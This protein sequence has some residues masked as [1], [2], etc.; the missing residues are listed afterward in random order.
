MTQR[1]EPSDLAQIGLS[2]EGERDLAAVMGTGWF[3]AAQDA[4]R[5]AIA[6]ALAADVIASQDQ[7]KG[8]ETKYNFIGGIDDDGKI[9][10]LIST[11][12]PDDAKMPARTAERLAHAG[13]RI[14][15]EKLTKEDALLSVSIGYHEEAVG[16]EAPK[17]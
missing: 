17:A 16:Q 10:A 8:T 15:A 11:F 14:L 4:Y 12:R 7:V 9:R 2:P 5:M 1:T 13:L 3:A 6:A